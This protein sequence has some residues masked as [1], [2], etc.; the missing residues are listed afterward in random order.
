MKVLFVRGISGMSNENIRKLFGGP[1]VVE[2]VVVPMDS[3]RGG[4]IG[5]F[6]RFLPPLPFAIC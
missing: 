1:D 5:Y 6:L 2:K 3:V 4:P